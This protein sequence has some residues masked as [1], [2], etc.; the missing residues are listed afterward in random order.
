MK[1]VIDSV[2]TAE[3]ELPSDLTAMLA[4]LLPSLLHQMEVIFLGP[5]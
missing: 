1:R 5:H 4:W 2:G 3:L